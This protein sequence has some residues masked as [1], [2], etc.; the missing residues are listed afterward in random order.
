MDNDPS[1]EPAPSR[2]TKVVLVD[3]QNFWKLVKSCGVEIDFRKLLDFLSKDSALLEAVWHTALYRRSPIEGILRAAEHAGFTRCVKPI[4]KTLEEIQN[5]ERRTKRP[6]NGWDI[7][8]NVASD[9]V[10]FATTPH[11]RTGRPVEMITLISG[12]LIDYFR[13]ITRAKSQGTLIQVLGS[14]QSSDGTTSASLLENML[15]VGLID[16]YIA[17][18]D[19]LPLI[20]R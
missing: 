19:V 17:Y 5:I 4:N 9:L 15:K 6:F 20:K 14:T 1:A 12:N 10:Y 13:A 8:S 2:P 16:R 18:E 3:G 7:D 11:I